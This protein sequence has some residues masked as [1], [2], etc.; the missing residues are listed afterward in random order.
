MLQLES[1]SN[2]GKRSETGISN[3]RDSGCSSRF[4]GFIGDSIMKRIPLTQGKFA[5][6]DDADFE[7]LSKYKWCATKCKNTYYAT[8]GKGISMHR[9]ILKP[10]FP[11]CSDH[12]DRN[13]L[14]NRRNNLRAVTVAQNQWN[15][16]ACQR[17]KGIMWHKRDRKWVARI[18]HYGQKIWLGLYKHKKDAR[19]AYLKAKLELR[20]V[21]GGFLSE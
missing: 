3:L 1:Q 16:K 5:L 2:L 13:G 11:L 19:K 21:N 18:E 20:G 4:S 10:I 6:V 17:A 9:E 14:N 7:E 8:R 15:S 12:K